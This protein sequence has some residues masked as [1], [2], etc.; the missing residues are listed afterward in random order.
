MS[1]T[2]SNNA[3]L[4][5]TFSNKISDQEILTAWKDFHESDRWIPGANELND[6]SQADFS[7]ITNAGITNLADYFKSIQDKI[8]MEPSKIAVY[9]PKPLSYGLARMYDVLGPETTEPIKLFKDLQEAKSWLT[10]K[11]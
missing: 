5:I 9:A 3:Y 1:I 10:E 8:N 7:E 6:F 11:G 4:T 2:F